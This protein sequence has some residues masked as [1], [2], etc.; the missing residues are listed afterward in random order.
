MYNPLFHRYMVTEIG[1]RN[2]G[3]SYRY[4]MLPVRIT[5]CTIHK[6]HKPRAWQLNQKV[7]Y[8]SSIHFGIFNHRVC[9]SHLQT[10]AEKMGLNTSSNA[11][12]WKD[13]ALVELNVAVMHSY[14]VMNFQKID[15]Y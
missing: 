2:F 3:D 12:L 10:V 5:T 13:K 1:A 6:R 15:K 7:F 9:A 11:T 8:F 4:N 14:Q